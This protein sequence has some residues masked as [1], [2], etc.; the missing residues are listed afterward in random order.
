MFSYHVEFQHCFDGDTGLVIGGSNGLRTQETALLA[1]VPME[2]N[3]G[4]WLEVVLIEDAEDFDQVHRAGTVV[5]GTWRK[6]VSAA[7]V[8]VQ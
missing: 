1:R 2:L 4:R 6:N 8:E 5:V 7:E 3:G